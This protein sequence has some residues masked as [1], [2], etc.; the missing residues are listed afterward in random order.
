MVAIAPGWRELAVISAFSSFKKEKTPI[1]AK[2]RKKAPMLSIL[3]TIELVS[4]KMVETNLLSK[5]TMR[6]NYL[7]VV[8]FKLYSQAF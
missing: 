7:Y 2:I 8:G 3:G 6:V 5:W 1:I 4:T